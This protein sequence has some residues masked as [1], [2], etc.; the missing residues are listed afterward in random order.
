MK[1]QEG[2]VNNLESILNDQKRVFDSSEIFA[3]AKEVSKERKFGESFEVIVKLNVDPTQ[4]DQNVRGTCVLPAGTGKEVR[5]CVFAGDEFHEEC[6]AAGAEFIGNE[7]ILKDI[8]EG[9]ILF[10]KIIATPEFMPTLK[11]MARIL[12]PKGLMPN[13]KSGTLVKQHELIETV[14]ISRQGLIEFR[15][16]EGSFIMN[17]IGNRGF[18]IEDLKKNLDAIMLAIAK[19]KP[20]TVKGKYF[21]KAQIKTSMGPPLK[22]DIGAY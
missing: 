2:V 20:E 16:N 15:V 17:K 18:E 7:A 9:I 1:G 21:T 8:S 22:L 5:V 11:S 19:K 13:L 14:K 3:A 10:D 6:K 12:G 4:G